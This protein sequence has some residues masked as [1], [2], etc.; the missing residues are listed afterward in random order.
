MVLENGWYKTKGES[1]QLQTQ[2]KPRSL[3]LAEEISFFDRR[4]SWT[5]TSEEDSTSSGIDDASGECNIED[6]VVAFHVTILILQV[7][8]GGTRVRGR[9][10]LVGRESKYIVGVVGDRDSRGGWYGALCISVVH[11]VI[12][13]IAPLFLVTCL[14]GS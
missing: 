9:V 11:I 7:I 6:N 1:M 8:I 13:V 10:R 14:G 12:V 3:K 5:K 2:L 4:V